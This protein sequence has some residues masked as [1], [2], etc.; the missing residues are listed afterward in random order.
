MMWLFYFSPRQ[1]GSTGLRTVKKVQVHAEL[2]V[3]VAGKR[4]RVVLAL[5][6]IR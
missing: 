2:L 1:D 3:R 4:E 6:L 5:A